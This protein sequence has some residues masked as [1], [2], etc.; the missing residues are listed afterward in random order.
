LHT[1]AEGGK[2]NIL[3]LQKHL[4]AEGRLLAADVLYIIKTAT[5]ILRSEPTLLTVESPVT[6]CGDVHGQYYDLA[7]LFEIGG[8]VNKTTYL[9]LGDYVDRGSFSMEVLLH[10]YALKIL[11]RG[12]FFLI[13][14]NHECRHLTEY[15]TFREEAVR[16]YSAAVYE[17]AIE[18]FNA[19]PLGAVVSGQF[20]CIHGGISP[21]IKTLDD[22]RRIDR[23]REPPSFGPM[24]DLLW[25]DPAEDFAPAN[26]EHFGFNEVRGCS[27]VYTYNAAAAFLERN[28]LL[29]LVRAHEAQ[30]EGYRMYKMRETTGFPAVITI[31]S[32]PNYLDAYNNKG[33]V[34]RYDK[35]TLNIRQFNQTPHPYWLPNFIDVFTWSLPFVIEKIAEMQLTFLRMCDDEKEEALEVKEESLSERERMRRREAIREKIRAVSRFA[36][37][38]STLREEQETVKQI[39]AL[40]NQ[41]MLPRGVLLGGRLSLQQT[42][43]D[44]KSALVAD[45]PNERRPPLPEDASKKP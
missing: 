4:L 34:L 15:F 33:A 5:E 45:R 19:L 22:I 8:P 31:F 29:S 14:G 6:I 12:S 18:S 37:M 36:R 25:A 23:F 39:K 2:I 28:R 11:Y 30:D 24:C 9:F 27:Y 32:A 42:L 13:R 10:L 38:Y 41:E 35:S 20:L 21:E 44:F 1:Q 40:S 7:K 17:A 16:K 3:E 26:G 43:G